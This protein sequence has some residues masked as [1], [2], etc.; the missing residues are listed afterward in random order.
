MRPR[1]RYWTRVLLQI[2]AQNLLP[3][4]RFKI[5]TDMHT[6]VN[7][8]LITYFDSNLASLV[9]MLQ[10]FGCSLIPIL[11]RTKQ[12]NKTIRGSQESMV[13]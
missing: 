3:L 7:R 13:E 5:T 10:L 11:P 4:L 12:G 1:L 9:G 2:E 8:L 6:V